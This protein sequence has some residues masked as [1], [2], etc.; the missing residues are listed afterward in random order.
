MDAHSSGERTTS[1]EGEFTRKA[2]KPRMNSFVIERVG[3]SS[4]QK[5]LGR[6]GV[7]SLHVGSI[8]KR[9]RNRMIFSLAVSAN[10]HDYEILRGGHGPDLNLQRVPRYDV[11]PAREGTAAA[12]SGLV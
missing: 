7:R 6:V 1:P 4:G 3:N 9:V 12:S 2:L 11:S 8:E 5:L 10:W